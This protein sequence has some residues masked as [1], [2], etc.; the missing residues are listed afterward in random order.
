MFTW[1]VDYL[2]QSASGWTYPLVTLLI[3]L[4]ASLFLGFL[5]PGEAPAI[6]GGVLAGRAAVN[7]WGIAAS[8]VLGAVIGDSFTY[9]LGRWIGEARAVRWGKRIGVTQE[10]MD[11][12]DKFFAAHGGKAIF[13]GR[14]AS[15]FRPV[16]PFVAGASGLP[17]SRFIL[18]NLPAGVVWASI[19]IGL[20]YWAGEEWRQVARWVDRAGWIVLIVVVLFVLW[21]W[22]KNRPSGA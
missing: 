18:F 16:V 14:F 9:L 17:Y 4:D 20:G 12:A 2:V 6:V 3:V 22:M 10:R 11:R 5:L 15:I 21:H 19:F 8:A 13:A 1:L 7:L